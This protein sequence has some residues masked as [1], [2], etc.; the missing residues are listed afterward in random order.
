MLGLLRGKA[1]HSRITRSGKI[2][3]RPPQWPSNVLD[4]PRSWN[5]KL[6]IYRDAE[7]T[8]YNLEVVRRISNHPYP[9]KFEIYDLEAW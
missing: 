6:T 9:W 8:L 7:T 5:R 1:K 3:H 4:N 2:R